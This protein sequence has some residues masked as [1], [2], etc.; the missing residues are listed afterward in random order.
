M[1]LL[2]FL[3]AMVTLK[4]QLEELCSSLI[5]NR[6][7]IKHLLSEIPFK[8]ERSSTVYRLLLL[9]LRITFSI[10]KMK[11]R[12]LLKEPIVD[13]PARLIILR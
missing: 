1:A 4:R 3:S 8:I 9:E 5:N 7:D 13:L 10:T 11:T 6:K 2:P 12:F